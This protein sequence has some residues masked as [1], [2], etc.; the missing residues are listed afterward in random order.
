MGEHIYRIL[1]NELKTIR[2]KCDKCK[3]VV[4]VGYQKLCDIFEQKKCPVCHKEVIHSKDDPLADLQNALTTLHNEKDIQ[5][6]F[7]IDI[8]NQSAN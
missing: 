8:A 3:T 6:E 5:V 1:S 4:E 2:V 7:S